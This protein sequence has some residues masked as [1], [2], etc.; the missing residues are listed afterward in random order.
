M[1]NI[2]EFF[3]ADMKTYYFG[4]RGMP[5]P[6]MTTV[7]SGSNNTTMVSE[8]GVI[9]EDLKS[10]NA[11]PLIINSSRSFPEVAGLLYRD[12]P[13]PSMLPSF[14]QGVR[15]QQPDSKRRLQFLLGSAGI[16]KSYGASVLARARSPQGDVFVDCGGKN[17]NELLFETV[18][19]LDRAKNLTEE[20]D[21]RA[22]QQRLSP[23][24]LK[25]IKASFPGAYDEDTKAIDWDAVTAYGT[26]VSVSVLKQVIAFEKLDV[27]T[28]NQLGLTTRPGPVIRAFQEGRPLTLDEYNKGKPGTDSNLQVLWQFFI[29][30]ID[31]HTVMGGAGQTFTFRRADMKPGFAVTLTGNKAGDGQTTHML[32]R[33]AYQRLQP[34]ELGDPQVI[35]YQHRLCQVLTGVPVSTLYYM[36]QKKWDKDK[37]GFTRFLLK[38]RVLGLNSEEREAIPMHQLGLLANWESTLKATEKLASFYQGWVQV[39][40]P[41]SKLLEDSKM[42]DIAEEVDDEYFLM[43]GIGFRRMMRH[44][45]DALKGQSEIH[46]KNDIVGFDLDADWQNGPTAEVEHDLGAVGSFLGNH[47]NNVIV[48]DIFNLTEGRT[49]LRSHMMDLAKAAGLVNPGKLNEAA[50]SGDSTIPQLLNVGEDRNPYLMAKKCQS[51][52]AAAY[53]EDAGTP[54]ELFPAATVMTQVAEAKRQIKDVKAGI[55]FA[56]AVNPDLEARQAQ[57]FTVVPIYNS[58]QKADIQ[59]SSI[60]P[61]SAFVEGMIVAPGLNYDPSKLCLSADTFKD[62]PEND[63]ATGKPW[64]GVSILTGKSNVG[65]ASMNVIMDGSEANPDAVSAAHVLW[66]KKSG[67]MVV[68]GSGSSPLASVGSANVSYIDAENENAPQLLNDAVG[69]LLKGSKVTADDLQQACLFMNP[70]ADEDCTVTDLLLTPGMTHRSAVDGNTFGQLMQPKA[71]VGG[72]VDKLKSA[73]GFTQ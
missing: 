25:L 47:L 14:I 13:V 63:P 34:V 71:G 27:P 5:Y 20:I 16:G 70:Q 46:T 30:E 61:L 49:H 66:N 17:L 50:P 26:E 12:M 21:L 54:D 62:I 35:D 48:Q 3:Q 59:L 36:D 52:L 51:I 39:T 72:I 69:R 56:V 18:L 41:S 31:Q 67:E 65:M 38:L 73:V 64:M 10:P 28:G 37:E 15:Y 33:S 58:T 42:S 4:V 11:H 53:S 22:G 1:D 68:V 29:G 2:S 57:P 6:T 8:L 32:A 43:S 23:V 45:S 55:S 24:S 40:D 19:D 60:M 9:E 44:C 7:N